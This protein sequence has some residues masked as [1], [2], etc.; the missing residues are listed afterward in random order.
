MTPADLIT[1]H[2]RRWLNDE[3]SATYKWTQAELVDYYNTV[4]DDIA[5]ETEY[6]VDAHTSTTHEITVSAGTA[7]YAY[8]ALMLSDYKVYLTGVSNPLIHTNLAMLSDSN[9]SWRY[10]YSIY[11]TD[12]SFADNTPSAD[13]I[14][15]T[16]TDFVA[17]PIADDDWINVI[18][19]TS[20]NSN[21]QVDTAAKNLL[22]LK[23]TAS[24]TTEIAGDP[25]SIRVLNTDT[26]TNYLF[27]Y[28]TGYITLYPCPNAAGK[29]MIECMKY[30]T[31]PL[32]VANLSSDTIPLDSHYHLRLSDGILKYAYLKSGPST[33]NIEKSN[34]HGARAQQLIY[35]IKRDLIRMRS[36][37]TP[38]QPHTGAI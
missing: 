17:V 15:S 4:I 30:Q 7:D 36:P 25:V 12:I 18:G 34:I 13:S 38:I 32:T 11:G 35:E 14:A 1:T 3:T 10:T 24:L 16:T 28:R 31:T 22:T 2:C 33:F 27:D 6:L 9:P 26:P 20:N 19:S 29:L 8:S 23:T 21:Y 5:R 37:R